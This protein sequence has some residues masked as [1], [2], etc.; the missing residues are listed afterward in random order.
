MNKLQIFQK[1][2]RYMLEITNQDRDLKLRSPTLCH[3]KTFSP[4]LGDL[5]CDFEH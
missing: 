3:K 4:D 5:L 1:L 2:S